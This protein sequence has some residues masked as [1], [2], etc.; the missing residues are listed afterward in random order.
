VHCQRGKLRVPSRC[1]VKGAEVTTT[2]TG[3]CLLTLPCRGLGAH[4]EL[5]MQHPVA[6]DDHVGIL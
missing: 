6:P 1:P 4:L 5:Q 3:Q 2:T